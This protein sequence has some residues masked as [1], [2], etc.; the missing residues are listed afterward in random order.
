MK[1]IAE[2]QNATTEFIY[3]RP[4]YINLYIYNYPIGQEEYLR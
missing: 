3:K 2:K 4:E 1:E